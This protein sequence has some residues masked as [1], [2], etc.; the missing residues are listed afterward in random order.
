MALLENQLEN[1]VWLQKINLTYAYRII[2]LFP[3]WKNT[4]CEDCNKKHNYLSYLSIFSIGSKCREKKCSSLLFSELIFFAAFYLFQ[5]KMGWTPDFFIFILLFTLFWI[6]TVIDFR[7]Y[8]IPDEVNYLGI[9]L[10]LLIHGALHVYQ[11]L[12]PES[13]SQH[14]FYFGPDFYH[15]GHSIMGVVLASGILFSIAYLTSTYLKR[16]AMGGGDIKLI[17]FIGAFLGYKI[18][19]ISLAISSL[20]G[21]VFGII[22]MI[23]SKWIDKSE[24]FTMIAYGPYIILATLL[25][26][27]FTP[28]TIIQ[29]YEQLSM[30]FVHN[31]LT[32]P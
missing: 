15:I 24:G 21:S 10:G 5:S 4:P 13:Y 11:Y 22:I 1:Q 32:T 18:A 28:D 29:W 16:E 3:S 6:I 12:K 25:V 19:L 9:L 8:I 31:Y 7:Y 30:A 26:V 20:L 23:R 14:V 17:A 2:D 27:Y